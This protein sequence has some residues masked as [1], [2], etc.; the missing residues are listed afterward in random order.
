VCLPFFKKKIVFEKNYCLEPIFF[1]AQERAK[2]LGKGDDK[3][4]CDL[5]LETMQVRLVSLCF[6][7]PSDFAI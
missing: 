3:F 7:M 1:C 6:Q 2:G 4:D 5:I